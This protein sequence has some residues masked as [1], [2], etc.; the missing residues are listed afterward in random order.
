MGSGIQ[1]WEKQCVPSC[2][3][4]NLPDGAH[5]QN[6]HFYSSVLKHTCP[7]STGWTRREDPSS[8]LVCAGTHH[9]PLLF[10]SC[11]T[12]TSHSSSSW[13]SDTVTA[14]LNCKTSP[15]PIQ[16]RFQLWFCIYL[17]LSLSIKSNQF[18]IPTLHH[19]WKWNCP[20]FR[21]QELLILATFFT[22]VS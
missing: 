10:H 9:K 17:Q 11:K 22:K 12:C 21:V 14:C 5:D 4:K 7:P 18:K 13:H 2:V 6:E 19:L 16:N 8:S 20:F 3:C 1:P 15:N